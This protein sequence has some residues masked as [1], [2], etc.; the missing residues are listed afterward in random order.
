KFEIGKP[1][2]VAARTRQA[3]NESLADGI[4]DVD[5]HDR[6]DAGCLL[7][8]RQS[9]RAPREDD[10]R[11]ETNQFG[12]IGHQPSDITG[13]PTLVDAQVAA[14][15]PPRF[16]ET[17]RKRGNSRLGDRVVR[18]QRLKYSDPPHPLLLRTCRERPRY[19]RAAE[20]RDERAPLHSITSSARR[21][22]DSG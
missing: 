3:R 10:I 6:Y 9:G 7:R 11:S 20:Q 19:S 21:R 5:K 18:V 1:G 22:K 16:L 17:V 2:G 13:G 4:G 15:R 14:F 12:R 8:R